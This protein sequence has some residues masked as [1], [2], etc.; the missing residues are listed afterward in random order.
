MLERGMWPQNAN[1]FMCMVHVCCVRVH[2]MF[3]AGIRA[4][5]R[6]LGP[7]ILRTFPATGALFLA[8]E[9]TKKGLGS[10]ADRA[11]VH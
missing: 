5:Y 4:L 11:G 9:T 6:G 2:A 8:Y 7:T 1:V 3:A 10:L